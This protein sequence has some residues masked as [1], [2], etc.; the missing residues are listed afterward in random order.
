M[1]W[2][3]RFKLRLYIAGDTQNSSEAR[4]N[5][6]ALCRTY[7]PNRH[8][9]EIVDVFRNPARALGDGIFLTPTLVKVSPAPGRKIV[10]TLSEAQRVL[11]ALGLATLVE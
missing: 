7:L 3:P 4:A 11:Q 2:R 8:D 9:I 5:L 10:G 6:A 1:T